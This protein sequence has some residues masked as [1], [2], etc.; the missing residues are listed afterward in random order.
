MRH[1]VWIAERWD[2]EG[3]RLTE[4]AGASSDLLSLLH[5]ADR[6]GSRGHAHVCQKA[7]H[8]TTVSTCEH[9]CSQKYHEPHFPSQP[10]TI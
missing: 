5:E 10:T 4:S 6:G 2:F 3:D 9:Q 8:S 7:M 1:R